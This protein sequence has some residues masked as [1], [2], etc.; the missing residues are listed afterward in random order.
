MIITGKAGAEAPVFRHGEE[1][2]FQ[3]IRLLFQHKL[4]YNIS[5][6]RR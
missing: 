5:S 4:L 6:E 2:P 1:A 3:L